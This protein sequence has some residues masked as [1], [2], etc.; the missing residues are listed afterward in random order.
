MASWARTRLP[1]R[2]EGTDD[3]IVRNLAL[4][5][6]GFGIR[7]LSGWG[8]L[9][10]R[11]RAWPQPAGASSSSP[12]FSCRAQPSAS[13]HG[14]SASQHR[15]PTRPARPSNSSATTPTSTSTNFTWSA[16]PRAG[17]RLVQMDLPPGAL[18]VLVSRNGEHIVPQ[19]QTTLRPDDLVLLLASD[20]ALDEIRRLLEKPAQA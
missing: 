11:A 18:V 17:R 5:L 8:C 12:P 16:A 4:L 13:R 1:G 15:R 20:D 19:G 10:T 7:D 14:D 3:Q 9:R 6:P 2:T